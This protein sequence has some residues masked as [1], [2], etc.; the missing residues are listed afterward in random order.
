[1]IKGGR[2]VSKTRSI[3]ASFPLLTI[4]WAMGNSFMQLMHSRLISMHSS[5]APSSVNLLL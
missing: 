5:I 1:M 3:P 4:K 2:V